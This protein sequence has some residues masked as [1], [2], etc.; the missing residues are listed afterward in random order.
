MW[1]FEVWGIKW[2][3]RWTIHVWC[4]EC[5][6]IFKWIRPVSKSRWVM[7]CWMW[8]I[9]KSFANQIFNAWEEKLQPRVSG[10]VLF[11][12][13]GYRRK[14]CFA[15]FSPRFV[16]ETRCVKKTTKV[17]L[18]CTGELAV[19]AHQPVPMFWVNRLN[20]ERQQQEAGYN[21]ESA[22]KQTAVVN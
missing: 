22:V 18:M 16:G 7:K 6:A 13:A 14:Q 17:K 1:V 15:T 12:L 9:I 8:F 5:L 4:S 20:Q 21:H 19:C 2:I 3:G 11:K 10:R